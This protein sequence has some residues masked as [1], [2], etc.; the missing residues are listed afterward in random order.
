MQ[1]LRRNPSNS[2]YK[3][4]DFTD[5]DAIDYSQDVC[6]YFHHKAPTCHPR[7]FVPPSPS[8]HP[9][10]ALA[11]RLKHW[12]WSQL[13]LREQPW[14]LHGDDADTRAI[15]RQCLHPAQYCS[16]SS[17]IIMRTLRRIPSYSKM[18]KPRSLPLLIQSLGWAETCCSSSWWSAPP[19]WSSTNMFQLMFVNSFLCSLLTNQFYSVLCKYFKTFVFFKINVR[20]IHFRYLCFI[21]VTFKVN[22]STY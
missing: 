9:S 21:I 13:R 2:K 8:T 15:N 10:P 22:N 11:V 12:R 3:E 20:N 19:S 1:T 4:D 16:K 14:L 6:I 5:S 18:I 17:K 7:S